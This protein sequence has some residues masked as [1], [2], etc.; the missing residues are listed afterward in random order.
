MKK[1]TLA[2]AILCTAAS[3]SALASEVF[4]DRARVISSRPIKDRI[5]VAREECWNDVQRGY[6]ERRVT[7]SDTGAAIGPGTVLGAIVG[8]VAGHQVGSGRGN[9]AATAAGAV[10][11]GLI[12]NQADRDQG[13]V[14]PGGRVTEVE[15]VP[16]ERNVERCRT[17]NE[18]REA[19]L[20]YEVRY[21]Y[22]GRQFT[23]RM[24]R[25]PGRNLRVNVS[26]APAEGREMPP[27]PPPREP[28]P[29]APVYR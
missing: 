14:G 12:G 19:T 5:P 16:V 28:R 21:E 26:V 25:D 2:T 11:G 13:R 22:G 9:D 6:E 7:R 27:G 3:A 24:D 29:G 17:V 10:I 1:L 4:S 15:R 18:V 8:G 23:T 20:G